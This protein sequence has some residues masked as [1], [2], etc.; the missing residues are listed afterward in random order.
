[1]RVRQRR[2]LCHC[3]GDDRPVAAQRGSRHADAVPPH[4][5]G[6]GPARRLS[7]ARVLARYR[8]PRRFAPGPRRIA[9]PVSMMGPALIV[10]YGAVG[11]RHAHVLEELGFSVAVVSRRGAAEGRPAFTSVAHAFAGRSFNYVVVADETA[12]HADSLAQIARGGHSGYV[13]V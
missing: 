3:A 10:G 2:H 12:R 9:E 11:A 8:S 13:L 4:C 5:R 6:S 7:P 1:P